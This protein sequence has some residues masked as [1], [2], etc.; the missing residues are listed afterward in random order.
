MG[1]HLLMAAWGQ[2]WGQTLPRAPESQASGSSGPKPGLFWGGLRAM[3]RL[4]RQCLCN[5]HKSCA[6][7]GER[8]DRAIGNT[9]ICRRLSTTQTVMGVHRAWPWN[10]H[11]DTQVCKYIR[12]HALQAPLWE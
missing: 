4:S 7:Q 8:G 10:Q 3:V 5:W 12:S 11:S 9:C 2:V 1:S 6:T